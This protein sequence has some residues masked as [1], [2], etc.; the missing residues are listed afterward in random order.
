MQKKRKKDA[1]V[2]AENEEFGIEPVVHYKDAIF[3]GL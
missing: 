3:L 2:M 1:V